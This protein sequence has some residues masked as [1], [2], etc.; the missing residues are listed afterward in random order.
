MATMYVYNIPSD[1]TVNLRNSPSSDGTVL[2]RVPYGSAVEASTSST[3]GW[4]NA[5]YGG[6]NGY[7]MSQYLTID[8]SKRSLSRVYQRPILKASAVLL[9][10]RLVMNK[11]YSPFSA[12]ISH[13][14]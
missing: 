1:E 10:T 3:S 6:Y 4:H 7:I 14:H 2:V 12:L 13:A 5:S 9:S 11:P 8:K